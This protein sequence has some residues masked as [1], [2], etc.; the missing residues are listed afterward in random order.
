MNEEITKMPP[1]PS[2][3]RLLQTNEEVQRG[4]LRWSPERK[5]WEEIVDVI[6]IRV[7]APLQGQ[8]CRPA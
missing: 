4:D 7:P 8:Y 6:N 1:V 3:A 2:G 5:K